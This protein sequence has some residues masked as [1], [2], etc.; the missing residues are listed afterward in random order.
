MDFHF[1]LRRN[2]GELRGWSNGEIDLPL[3]N[4][5]YISKVVE[6]LKMGQRNSAEWK[7]QWIDHCGKYGYGKQDPNRHDAM[8]LISFVFRFG[9]A[10][11]VTAKWA[12]E[13]SYLVALGELAKPYMVQTV[14]QGRGSNKDWDS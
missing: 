13:G 2:V 11:V 9:L 1:T 3:L 14:N 12:V 4:S 10:E 8:F 7:T 6:L 5:G